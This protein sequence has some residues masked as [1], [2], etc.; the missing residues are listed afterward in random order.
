[1]R[2]EEINKNGGIH[3]RKI[4]FVVEDTQYQ[5]LRAIQAA[6]KLINRDE[7]FAMLLALGTPPN[8]AVLTQQL[9]A[10]VPNLFPLTGARGMVEPFHELKFSSGVFTMTRS[11]L[12]E[13]FR[14]KRKKKTMCYLSRHRLWTGN[15]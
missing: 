7:I 11:V 13:I 10:G 8:N 15:T 2:F 14:G 1:M 6:N 12:L 9:A 3:G 4:R 5:I